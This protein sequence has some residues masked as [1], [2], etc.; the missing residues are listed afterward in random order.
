LRNSLNADNEWAGFL[1]HF[2]EV[3]Q[4]F[5]TRLKTSHPELTAND[6]RFICYVYMNL[7]AKEIA[8]MLNI[9]L[10]ACRKRKERI[11]QKIGLKDSTA[12]YSYLYDI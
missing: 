2:E 4:G 3:N 8:G 12:L 7:S 9:S 10:D 11:S 6:I 5:L 1:T